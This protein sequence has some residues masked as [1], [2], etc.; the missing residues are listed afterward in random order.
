[1]TCRICGNASGNTFYTARE[2][3]IGL[4]HSFQYF[5]C[6][7]CGCLQISQFP[8][9]IADYYPSDYNGFERPREDLYAGL[10]GWFRK[11]R[12]RAAL[13]PS[14]PVHFF[15]NRFFPARQYLLPGRFNLRMDARI[16]DVGCG[17]GSYLY[18][19]YE[20]GLKGVAGVD[21]FIGQTIRYANGYTIEKKTIEQVDGTW[22]LILYNHSF[23]HV[24]DPQVHLSRIRELLS[25]DGAAII[26]IPTASSYA[27]EHY[28]TDWFQLDAPRHFYLHTQES[29]G[30]L[31]GQSG[32][33]LRDTVYDSDAMQFIISELYR[34]D[35]PMSQMRQH[36]HDPKKYWQYKWRKWRY[37]ELARQ[38]NEEKRGDQ[39]AFILSLK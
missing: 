35:I 30:R 26:R 11:V 37:G 18:P 38:L 3:M 6:H 28:R 31:A 4:R 12:Y 2:M 29:M 36:T 23:E 15:I 1:M 7:D 10:S 21:P 39:A 25:P 13:F 9:N 27:W 8:K 20:L 17:G 16:L 5:E 14:G 34:N 22:D 32:L 19:L 33:R 24:P